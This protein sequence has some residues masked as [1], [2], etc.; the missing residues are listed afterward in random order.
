MGYVTASEIGL[1]WLRRPR[2]SS[3]SLVGG[4]LKTVGSELWGWLST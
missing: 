4:A 1:E 3:I 2:K